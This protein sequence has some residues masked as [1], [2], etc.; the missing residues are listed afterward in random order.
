MVLNIGDSDSALD[1]SQYSNEIGSQVEV[2][3]SSLQSGLDNGYVN[4]FRLTLS[5][6]LHNMCYFSYCSALVDSKNFVAKAYVGYVLRLIS[7][8]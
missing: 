2:A 4:F 6:M 5:R 3:I 8:A 7:N 1:L